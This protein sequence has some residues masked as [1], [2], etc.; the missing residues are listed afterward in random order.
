MP[1]ITI[2]NLHLQYRGPALFDGVSC[3][4]EAGERIGLLGRNGSGKTTLMR[5]LNREIEPDDGEIILEPDARVALLQQDV[6]TDITGSVEDVVAQGVPENPDDGSDWKSRHEVDQII[7]RM[8]L[9]GQLNFETLSSG[10]KRR[11]LL[12][13]QLVCQPRSFA[14]RRAK[15]TI[16]ISQP[17]RGSKTFYKSGPEHFCLLHMTEHFCENSRLVFSK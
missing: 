15:R 1:L 17:L 10:M 3:R 2:N 4:V 14:A 13:Q 8:E 7:A 16:W 5:L 6:P 9:D 12:A 11:V